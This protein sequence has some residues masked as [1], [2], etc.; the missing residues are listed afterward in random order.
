MPGP[1]YPHPVQQS[2]WR[3]L[4]THLIRSSTSLLT[5]QPL[6]IS[7]SLFWALV[8]CVPITQTF[9]YFLARHLW[10]SLGANSNLPPQAR[11]RRM[12]LLFG[13]SKEDSDPYP[14][15]FPLQIGNW[16]IIGFWWPQWRPKTWSP[17]T[18]P[19][20][21][22]ISYSKEN[23]GFLALWVGRGL[24]TILSVQTAV[25][26]EEPCNSQERPLKRLDQQ[27]PC[28]HSSLPLPT[29]NHLWAVLQG[30]LCCTWC[31]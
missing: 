5:Q 24:I 30:L 25:E 1:L 16:G 27:S 22:L 13:G 10:L 31:E 15:V 17:S 21:A 6:Y 23:T 4:T 2:C 11:A 9:S 29:P 28:F 3:A 12:R 26:Q 14:W 19:S 18:G 20:S 7:F 8:Y